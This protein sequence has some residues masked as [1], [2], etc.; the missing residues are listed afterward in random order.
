MAMRMIASVS[1][2]FIW[3]G[4]KMEAMWAV[5]SGWAIKKTLSAHLNNPDSAGRLLKLLSRELPL[6]RYTDEMAKQQENHNLPASASMASAIFLRHALTDWSKLP[7]SRINP[8][9]AGIRF[10]KA[11]G[12]RVPVQHISPAPFDRIIPVKG[13]VV[14]PNDAYSATGV[15]IVRTENDILELS[16][17]NVFSQWEQVRRRAKH[18]LD[19]HLAGSDLWVVEEYISGPDGH[20]ANDVK[21]NVFY[22]RTGWIIEMKRHPRFLCYRMDHQGNEEKSELYTSDQTFKG[23]GASVDEIA[24]V[25]RLSLEIPV[26]F[27]RIDFLR[28]KDGLVFNEFTPRP[29]MLGYFNRKND[30]RFGRMYHEAEVRLTAD[31]LSGKQFKLFHGT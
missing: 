4:L 16:T 30:R 5:F 14:K 7:E 8:K 20:P 15:F 22:G 17:G 12:L 27:M 28:G 18:L 24:M 19:I 1:F 23:E 13:S 11:A 2:P 26:P 10:A 21:F 31:L 6:N 3:M 25:E 9:D 29:G